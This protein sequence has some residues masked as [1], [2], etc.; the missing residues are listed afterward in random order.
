MANLEGNINVTGIYR[1]ANVVC[2]ER[3]NKLISTMPERIPN[4]EDPDVMEHTCAGPEFLHDIVVSTYAG[5]Y[6]NALALV[7]SVAQ[8]QPMPILDLMDP[9][10]AGTLV[11]LPSPSFIDTVI[12][13]GAL[14]ELAEL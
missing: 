13:S 8:F 3:E 7:E 9:L 4:G 6:P 12:E 10:P 14:S 5:L 2:D 1:H 11:L